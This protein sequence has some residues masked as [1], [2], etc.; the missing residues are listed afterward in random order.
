MLQSVYMDKKDF[1]LFVGSWKMC[2]KC[3]DFHCLK[4]LKLFKCKKSPSSDDVECVY[5]DKTNF[6]LFVGS[7]KMCQK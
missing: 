3:H 1:E 4:F 6:E 2:Q 5:S 7:W